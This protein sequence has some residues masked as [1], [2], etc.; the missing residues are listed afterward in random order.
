MPSPKH[1]YTCV[2]ALAFSLLLLVW[3]RPA[4]A[5]VVS[6]VDA[7]LARMVASGVPGVAVVVTRHDDVV[8]AT[9]RG[10]DGRADV[11]ADTRFR[12][13]SLSKS[14]TATAVL[15]LVEQQRVDLDRPVTTYLPE[16][17]IDDPRTDRIT[18]RHLLNQSSGLTDN[19]LGFGQYVDGPRTAKEAVDLLRSSRLAYDPGTSWDYCNVNYWVAARLVEVVSGEEFST[20]L[21]R[22]V[23]TPLGMTRT[24]QHDIPAEATDVARTHSYAFGHAVHVGD[25]PG[26]SGG[27][28]GVVTTAA[29]L[30]RWL[31]FQGGF[32]VPEQTGHVL[33][34]ELLAEMHRRQSPL[35]QYSVGYALGWWDGEPADGGIPR[36]SHSGTGGGFSAYQGF[37]P[38]GTGVGV[39]VNASQPTGDRIA[40]DLRAIVVGGSPTDAPQGPSPWPDILATLVALTTLALCARGIRNARAWPLRRKGWVRW[41]VLSLLAVVPAALLSLPWAGGRLLGREATWTVLWHMA[42]VPTAAAIMCAT[43]LILLVAARA[44]ALACGLPILHLSRRRLLS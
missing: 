6:D 43:G 40:G 20:Y 2:V 8:I 22:H 13:A 21:D 9:G 35:D 16:L 3:P 27:A 28:G 36:I 11:G 7:Y 15:Q 37:F 12:A 24:T 32:R 38:D 34:P 4:S 29:D 41:G 5:D 19:T 44:V 33:G 10:T 26:F 30:G 23:F 42:P 18:V 14:F 17:V 39:L 31:R 25:A 1:P